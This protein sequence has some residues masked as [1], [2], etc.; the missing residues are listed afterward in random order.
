MMMNQW[1]LGYKIPVEKALNLKVGCSETK[2][3]SIQQKPGARLQKWLTW[4][5]KNVPNLNGS[6]SGTSGNHCLSHEIYWNMINMVII[7]NYKQEELQQQMF[8]SNSPIM[9]VEAR[10]PQHPPAHLQLRDGRLASGSV[11]ILARSRW[12]GLS[13]NGSWEANMQRLHRKEFAE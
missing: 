9:I 1:I 4:K 6:A 8:P 3:G 7:C 2:P 10:S 5:K 13:F 11:S 12:Y